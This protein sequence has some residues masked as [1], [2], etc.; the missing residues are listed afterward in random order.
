MELL[1]DDSP[2]LA[3]LRSDRHVRRLPLPEQ[4][5]IID[6]CVACGENAARDILRERGCVDGDS[7]QPLVES[8][9]IYVN[10]LDT[11]YDLPYIAE[12][13]HRN[14]TIV[15]YDRRIRQM[16]QILAQVHPEYFREY[17]LR[18]MCLAHEL[19][20]HLES[21]KNGSTGKIAGV[22]GKLFGAIPITHWV[23]EGSEIAAHA[24]VRTLLNLSFQTYTFADEM[25]AY[26]SSEGK[27]DS[28]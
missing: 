15:L 13:T 9:G 27:G 17:S 23:A 3:R 11:K 2:Y 28:L 10:I 22:P 14:R 5:R 21:V 12:Y 4:K 16:Q 24:F 8:Y 6:R 26:L 25:A 18:H 19:F 7:L 1:Q 20:H